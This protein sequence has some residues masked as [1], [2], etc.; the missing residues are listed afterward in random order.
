MKKMCKWETKQWVSVLFP[1]FLS[2]SVFKV[3]LCQSHQVLVVNG[4][5][6]SSFPVMILRVF[7]NAVLPCQVI[8][9]VTLLLL[10]RFF[11]VGSSSDSFEFV[12]WIVGPSLPVPDKKR[13]HPSHSNQWKNTRDRPGPMSYLKRFIMWRVYIFTC[14]EEVQRRDVED[15]HQDEFKD[16]TRRS[17]VQLIVYKW[18]KFEL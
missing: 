7:K 11:H 16:W 4:P 5:Q 18:R 13:M 15:T 6:L 14:P 10:P 2:C 9:A 17:P 12:S 8:C 1:S 3:F